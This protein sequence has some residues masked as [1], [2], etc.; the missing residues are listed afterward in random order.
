M[1]TLNIGGKRVKVDDS[2]LSLP[3]DQ[4]QKTVD[5]IA[6]SLNITAEAPQTVAGGRGDQEMPVTKNDAAVY[7]LTD[8]LGFGFADEVGSG[9]AAGVGKLTG[10]PRSMGEIYTDF[11]NKGRA[12]QA[13]SAEQHPGDYLAGQGVGAV[14]TLP[15]G[16]PLIK[17]ATT[18]G[19]AWQG[20]KTGAGFG[21]LYGFGSGEG[22]LE[23]RVNSAAKGGFMGGAVGGALPVVARGVSGAYNAAKAPFQRPQTFATQKVAEAARRGGVTADQVTRDLMSDP[24]MLVADALGRSGQRLTRAVINKG[25]EGAES[26]YNTLATRQR[27]QGERAMSEVRAGLG[28][29]AAFYGNMD[30]ALTA[31]KTNAKPLYEGAYRQRINYQQYGPA[32][33][34]VWG[35]IPERLK[36]QIISAAN[37]ILVA[38]GKKTK[39]MGK[40]FGR[41]PKTGRITAQPTV[42]QWDYIKRGIDAV[43]ESQEGQAASGGM[44]SFGR[45]L[46]QVKNDLLG[47]LDEA[48]PQY[49]Q[50]RKIYAGD[51]EVKKALELGREALRFDP[52]QIAQT[53]SKMDTA[54]KEMFRAGFARALGDQIGGV[55]LGNNVIDRI[56]N[57]PNQQARLQAVFGS[58]EGFN[59]FAKFAQGEQKMADTWRSASGNSTTA[60]QVNDLMDAGNP[61]LEI[62]TQMA[63]SGP[64]AALVSAIMRYGRTLGGLTE[65]RANV[66]ADMLAQRGLSPELRQAL[67]RGELTDAVRGELSRLIPSASLLSVGGTSTPP[68]GSR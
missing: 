23:Q 57:T 1:A 34:G 43:I 42:E 6:S 67:S 48:V 53:L 50:A 41:D 21:A 2:F 51:L 62:G 27:G 55:R 45:A 52:E 4:Q 30:N 12:L 17:G 11:L 32:L 5:E 31:L 68:Q 58:R 29:P 8:T 38:E 46:S 49:G 60:Q 47:V 59:R 33:S 7:G 10:D 13:A 36:P 15:I 24:N 44:S 14:A 20:A 16:G 19:K 37:D 18:L 63:T 56:W 54:G 25:G 61:V 26:L 40:V 3:P 28:D 65:A 9:I 66:I 22:G 64:K 39:A 35:R